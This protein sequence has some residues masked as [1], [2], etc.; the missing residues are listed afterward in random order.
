MPSDTR[1]DWMKE[2][3]A[4]NSSFSPLI[5]AELYQE[6]ASLSVAEAVECVLAGDFLKKWRR[7][8]PLIPKLDVSKPQDGIYHN[9]DLSSQI[10]GRVHERFFWV[11]RVCGTFFLRWHS[12]RK[13][14]SES[15]YALCGMDTI[16]R[17]DEVDSFDQK[18]GTNLE[19]RK[20]VFI[21]SGSV[22]IQLA[23][24]TPRDA[25]L[26]ISGIYHVA[27]FARN[28]YALS[29]IKNSSIINALFTTLEP[30]GIP[31]FTSTK[32]AEELGSPKNK[33]ST[34]IAPVNGENENPFSSF[35]S[36]DGVV[37][38]LAALEVMKH[39]ERAEPIVAA[40]VDVVMARETWLH[41]L[42]K[43]LVEVDFNK[44]DNLI[45]FVA[46]CSHHLDI[47]GASSEQR[48][49]EVFIYDELMESDDMMKLLYNVIKQY[50]LRV[51]LEKAY[52]ADN[53]GK[54]TNNTSQTV[55]QHTRK[56][57]FGYKDQN[58]PE[59]PEKTLEKDFRSKD[60]TNAFRPI[61]NTQ[62]EYFLEKVQA[63]NRVEVTDNILE[64][65]CNSKNTVF[66]TLKRT[67]AKHRTGSRLKKMPKE[68]I[69]VKVLTI[70][71][72]HWSLAQKFNTVVMPQDAMEIANML[73]YPLTAFW[74]AS[75]H[76]TYLTGNQVGGTATA[77]AL[78]DALLR[79]CRCIELDCQ[80]GPDG[81]PVLCHSWKNCQLTGSV[82]LE[83][84]L[85]ACKETAFRASKLP[86][87]LSIQMRCSDEGKRKTANLCKM[88][89]GD[90]LYMPNPD[91]PVDHVASVPLGSLL[92]KFI[93]K[94][95]VN[96]DKE[97]GK[98]RA[99]KEWMS[100]VALHG[101]RMV[102]RTP[103]QIANAKR[104]DVYSM[105]E[106]KF[107]KVANHKKFMQ[108][109][110]DAAMI[111]IFPSGT[112]L[113]STNFCPL[114]T[115]AAGVQFA[116][117]NYQS[118]DRSMLINYGKFNQSFGYVL[119][120]PEL[121]PLSF[122]E[123][124][125]LEYF[126]HKP[127][128]LKIHVLSASQLSPPNE[129]LEQQNFANAL[130]NILYSIEQGGTALDMDQV[131]RHL[132]KPRK[133]K[134]PTKK[135]QRELKDAIKDG[136][137]VESDDRVTTVSKVIEKS[138]NILTAHRDPCC[139]FVEV[140]VLG[141]GER[142]Q[143]TKTVNFNSFN[144]VW[145]DVSPPF[146]FLIKHPN[147]AI[148]MLTVKHSDNM[149]TQLIG[150]TALPVNRIRPGIR[151]AQLLDQKFMEIECCGLLLHVEVKYAE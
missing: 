55:E 16:R 93:I 138:A 34:L 136:L 64:V 85:L 110:T 10:L 60:A 139:P 103:D 66:T 128:L 24:A 11:S 26:W 109:F 29:W 68:S 9:R 38:V 81:E 104:N 72:F 122:R 18:N 51:G 19:S 88:V 112:R 119:K 87:I 106:N 117:L 80:D 121:R 54:S 46:E 2:L 137:R 78:A 13:R 150:Q 129:G 76:N 99:E 31:S 146:E 58:E 27:R 1:H 82:T 96:G 131:A 61:D 30:K 95:K 113:A 12:R 3:A 141:E 108:T 94:G 36:L 33:L 92:S 98:S 90:V 39:A 62:Y 145:A 144:P 125:R 50:S 37:D 89:L 105:N 59:G 41:K 7:G 126:C 127:V 53:T 35:M 65:L 4:G 74:I 8:Q 102:D 69:P 147:L 23:A 52:E 148:L 6:V 32:I 135:Q 91:D 56:S 73:T 67:Q 70:M 83:K 101:Y 57:E 142:I 79:G 43:K 48:K 47:L 116:A 71:G 124:E 149:G 130:D 86:V 25:L 115:W 133:T 44:V 132:G 14:A 21:L 134:P 42:I 100:I 120:P 15:V 28:E 111:R 140:A 151:W 97:A 5:S 118:C 107:A 84:A 22:S 17:G 49:D 75:S 143:R 45:R 114:D 123:S 20:L 63:A 40:A 77:T